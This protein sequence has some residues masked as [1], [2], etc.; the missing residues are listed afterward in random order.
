MDEKLNSSGERLDGYSTDIITMEHLHRYA[1]TFPY[2]KNKKVLDIACGEGYGSYLMSAITSEMTGVDI[3]E[4]VIRTATAKYKRSGLRFQSGSALKIPMPDASVD[5]IVSFE[6]LE[7]LSEHDKMMLEFKR[8]LIPGGLLIISTPDKLNYS[9]K[10]G[11]KNIYHLKELYFH[12]FRSLL[13]QYFLAQ[14]VS[15]QY[16]GL[17]S[18]IIPEQAT[19]NH[20]VYSGNF[21]QIN[22]TNESK[23]PFL[24][25][26]ASDKHLPEQSTSHFYI[27]QLLE[28]LLKETADD[29]R[30]TF[31]YRTG[32][33]ILNPLKWIK[34]LIAK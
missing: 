34:K 5:V 19:G 22:D 4:K 13:S 18:V 23:A 16:S 10:T 27:D 3:N 15:Y 1:L 20:S 6:T 17:F 25:A 2:I 32:H 28:S 21:S 33:F 24:V 29:I 9:D 8:V 11:H 14:R 12:E 26:F 31:S 7:H 30:N